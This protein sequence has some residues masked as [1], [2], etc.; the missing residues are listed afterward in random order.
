MVYNNIKYC[1]SD[2]YYVSLLTLYIVLIFN[3]LK[4]ASQNII[5][6]YI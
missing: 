1:I 4:Y 3:V 2:F 5:V 6:I